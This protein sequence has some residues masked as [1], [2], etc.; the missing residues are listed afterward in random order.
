MRSPRVNANLALFGL[1]AGALLLYRF[2]PERYS[3]Y[4]SCP[5]FHYLHLYCP[6]CGSTRALS[7]L[8]HGHFSQA[9][10]YN[11]LF[12]VLLPLLLSLGGIAYWSAMTEEP[13]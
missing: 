8:L 6:G 13:I 11:P 4:P 5:V 12:V 3:F 2:P 10:Y 7:A 9:M 1:L